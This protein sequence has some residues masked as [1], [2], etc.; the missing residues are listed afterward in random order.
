MKLACSVNV[1]NEVIKPLSEFGKFFF[2][3]FMKLIAIEKLSS[4]I[5]IKF[6]CF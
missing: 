3:A 1:S 2:H 6:R 4:D 5:F